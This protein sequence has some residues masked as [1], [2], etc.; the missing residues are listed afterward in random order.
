MRKVVLLWC[1]PTLLLGCSGEQSVLAPRGEEAGEIARLFWAMT[2][3]LVLVLLGVSLCALL[4]GP[5]G[6]RRGE[7]GNRDL[8][9]YHA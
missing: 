8:R 9:R 6:R 7:R 1:L 5:S 3:F 2:I 4:P